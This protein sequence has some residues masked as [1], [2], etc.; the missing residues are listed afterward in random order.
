MLEKRKGIKLELDEPQQLQLGRG[1]PGAPK[2]EDDDQGFDDPNGEVVDTYNE[3]EFRQYAFNAKMRELVVVD[4]SATWCPPSRAFE[5][6]FKSL[7]LRYKKKAIFVKVN[8]D[9]QDDG[10]KWCDR[11]TTTNSVPEFQFY[12]NSKCLEAFAGADEAK[13]ERSIR[14]HCSGG[15]RAGFK[16][17]R[18]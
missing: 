12:K 4:F 13:V 10:G 1:G 18:L 3:R 8:V 2:K 5:P 17:L 11:Y 9:R 14:K 15:G 16:V 7:A 6:K